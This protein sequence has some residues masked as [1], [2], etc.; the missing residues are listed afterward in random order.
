MP[1][2]TICAAV[3]RVCM[4]GPCSAGC[5]EHAGP[6]TLRRTRAC[7]TAHCCARSCCAVN[8]SSSCSWL[9]V[10]QAAAY[11]ASKFAVRGYSDSL[12]IELAPFGVQV[13]HVTP[14][15]VVDVMP[16]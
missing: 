10:P 1:T 13:M 4:Q 15:E 5:A 9:A 7:N 2:D 16:L 11:S 6:H 12:R 3:G 8:I 14:G